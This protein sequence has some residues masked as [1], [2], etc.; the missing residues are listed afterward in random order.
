MSRKTMETGWSKDDVGV[1]TVEENV[2]CL[3][4][5]LSLPGRSGRVWE[6]TG[7]VWEGTTPLRILLSHV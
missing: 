2:E 3:R 4:A 5:S 7:R 1:R 6:G